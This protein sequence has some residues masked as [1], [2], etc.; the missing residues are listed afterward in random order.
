MTIA[1][2]KQDRAICVWFNQREDVHEEKTGEFLLVTL[3][4]V[5]PCPG[6]MTAPASA[7]V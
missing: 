4:K 6:Q 1:A 3:Q 2:V 5:T 7:E